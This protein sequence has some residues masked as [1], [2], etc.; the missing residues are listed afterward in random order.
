MLANIIQ[1]YRDK[2]FHK[3]RQYEERVNVMIIYILKQYRRRF[4]YT[5][6]NVSIK[7]EII[8]DIQIIRF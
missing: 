1:G 4:F 6:N 2:S 8:I 3:D 5:K 7:V